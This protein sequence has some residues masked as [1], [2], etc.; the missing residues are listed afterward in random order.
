MLFGVWS[1]FGY[2]FR[3]ERY[4]DVGFSQRLDFDVHEAHDIENLRSNV[5]ALLD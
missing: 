1:L 2:L 4:S 5:W 3:H